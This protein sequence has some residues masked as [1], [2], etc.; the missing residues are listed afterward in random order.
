MDIVLKTEKVS[1]NYKSNRVLNNVS[2]SIGRGEIVALLGQNGAGK[3]T[4]IKC[5][6]GTIQSYQG[7]ISVFG[8]S[9]RVLDNTLLQK[10]GFLVE[11][12]FIP[13]LSGIE[14]LA[15]LASIFGVKQTAV[16]EL[17]DMVSLKSAATRKVSDY[18]YGM[19]QRLGLAQ[20]L[21]TNPELLVLDEPTVG[22][23]PVGRKII[24]DKL[25]EFQSRGTTVLLS[26]H[27]LE[28]AQSLAS[29]AILISSGAI[30]HVVEIDKAHYLQITTCEIDPRIAQ[31][32]SVRFDVQLLN[33]NIVTHIKVCFVC[34]VLSMLRKHNA[35]IIDI[36]EGKTAGLEHY[37]Q[38]ENRQ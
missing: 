10:C 4:L 20:A 31:D 37:F 8:Q 24:C 1:K 33:K 18:S 6:M 19:R 25:L 17:L 7:S 32:M 2:F 36:S 29:R 26:T 30:T 14:N 15:I 22:L 28:V 13:Y 27:E 9:N 21:L 34:D 23:D 12:A 35:P 38:G 3:T 11:P 5:I 16:K